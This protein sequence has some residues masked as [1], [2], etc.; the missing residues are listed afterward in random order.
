MTRFFVYF[1][2]GLSLPILAATLLN[3]PSGAT[4]AIGLACMFIAQAL[5]IVVGAI[6]G[7]RVA[8]ERLA[9]QID[10]DDSDVQIVT[11]S[12]AVAVRTVQP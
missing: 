5:M 10:D 8:I 11:Q 3:T 7:R 9:A 2:F 6:V 12:R 4:F 1:G